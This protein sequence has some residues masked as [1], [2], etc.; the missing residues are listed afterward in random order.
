LVPLIKGGTDLKDNIRPAHASCNIR[1]QATLL[2]GP[3]ATA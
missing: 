2:E 1:K 3:S